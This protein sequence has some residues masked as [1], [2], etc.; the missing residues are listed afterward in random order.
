MEM[1]QEVGEQDSSKSKFEIMVLESFPVQ[2]YISVTQPGFSHVGES[3]KY[4]VQ[5]GHRS[6]RHQGT[7]KPQ[8]PLPPHA[9]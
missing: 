3:W 8:C 4:S 2:Y 6:W 1:A 7:A 9:L 5:T